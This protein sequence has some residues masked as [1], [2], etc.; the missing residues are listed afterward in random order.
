MYNFIPHFYSPKLNLYDLPELLVFP[1]V[2]QDVGAGVENKQ[3][4]RESTHAYS[5]EDNLLNLVFIKE[6]LPIR[7]SH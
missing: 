2:D 1:W 7:P 6:L 4:M 5:P 3:E